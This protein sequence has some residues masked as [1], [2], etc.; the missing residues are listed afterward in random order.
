MGK[1]KWAFALAAA[2]L[3]TLLYLGAIAFTPAGLIG[4]PEYR[5]PV[6]HHGS[7]ARLPVAAL[8]LALAVLVAVL[9]LRD[10]PALLSARL[11]RPRVYAAFFLLGLS[12]QLGPA[13]AHRMGLVELPLRVYL[14][15]HTSY[16][17]DAAKIL[18]MRVWLEAFPVRLRELGTH[19]RTHP[20]GAVMPFFV[21]LRAMESRPELAELAAGWVPRGDEAR[22]KLGLS[23][24]EVAAGGLAALFL[25]LIAAATVPLAFAL[26][27]ALTDDRRAGLA[28]ALF[29][30]MPAFG[31][32][33]PV[34]DHAL[35]F[36]ILLALWFTVSALHRR[37]L[38]KM[39][40]A[41]AIIGFGLWFGT[42]VL[43]AAPLCL[44][45]L[46]AGLFH[47]RKETAPLRN[48]VVL[49]LALTALLL[50]TGAAVTALIGTALDI[51]YLQIYRA[52]MESGWSFNNRVSGRFHAWMWML[53]DPYELAAFAGMAV[54]GCFLWAIIGQG[55]LLGARRFSA[56]NPWLLA[57]VVFLLALDL[58]GKVVYEASRLAWFTF[59]LIALGA[60]NALPDPDEPGYLPASAIL[61]GL[62]AASALTF[63]MIF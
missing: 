23:T 18:S 4:T 16:F 34:L 47:L 25:L 30:A 10:L 7:F 8:I 5:L 14:P 40:A 2:G 49:F 56:I 17:S 27:R 20:P 39:P 51:N 6:L 11:G 62:T 33:T 3:L 29:A 38:W 50:T 42:S 24:P 63:R 15:D 53:W 35:G 60:V 9:F 43:A 57:T 46:A 12:F 41:G 21:L 31:H 58:S 44:L 36:M 61:L 1:R 48:H 59:P 13:A 22:S 55:R 32:Q 52:V 37:A 45:F 19:T 28:A 54:S 26:G